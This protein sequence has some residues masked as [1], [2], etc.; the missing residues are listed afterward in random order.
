MKQIFICFLTIMILIPVTAQVKAVKS[1]NQSITQQKTQMK[2]LGT[3]SGVPLLISHQGYISD[4]TGT[5]ISGTLPMTFNFWDDS[6]AGSNALILSFPGVGLAKGVFTVNLDITP[7]DLTKQYWLET[8]VN[9]QTLAPR[10]RLTGAPYSLYSLTADT[11]DFVRYPPTTTDS[12]RASH[13]AD[14]A[15]SIAATSIKGPILADSSRASLLAD[16]AKYTRGSAHYIGESYGGGIVF[17]IYDNGNHG[18]VVSTTDVGNSTR[19]GNQTN[20]N[21]MAFADG[22]GAGK[23]NTALIIASQGYGDGITYAARVCNEYSVTVGGVSYGDWYLPSEY[24]LNLLYMQRGVVS[25][26]GSS[27]YW[28]SNEI[29]ATHALLQWFNGGAQYT[30]GKEGTDQVRAIRTF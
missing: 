23:A 18:L 22:L 14:S 30:I 25:G 4:S 2:P 26:L 1:F 9:G 7:L 16:T 27:Y 21:T 12:S 13:I 17:Y 6:T 11:A 8:V 15:K 3:T 29:D 10:I 24:E 5:G 28:S 20:T 19:W